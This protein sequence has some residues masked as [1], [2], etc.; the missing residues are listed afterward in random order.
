MTASAHRILLNGLV[1]LRHTRG[2]S[3]RLIWVFKLNPCR[4][5]SVPEP[6]AEICVE[7][8]GC[9]GGLEDL[10]SIERPPWSTTGTA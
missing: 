3:Y 5:F 1:Y 7:R 4:L 6:I 10:S 2:F 9:E 8:G